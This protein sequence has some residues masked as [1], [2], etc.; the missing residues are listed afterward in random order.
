MTELAKTPKPHVRSFAGLRLGNG[1][2]LLSGRWRAACVY[3]RISLGR[4]PRSSCRLE[5]HEPVVWR[6]K[7]QSIGSP[8]FSFAQRAT[9]LGAFF[10]VT[11]PGLRRDPASWVAW[12]WHG[13]GLLST[14]ISA[15]GA[16]PMPWLLRCLLMNLAGH[17]PVDY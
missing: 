11:R 13:V 17:R 3:K 12:C 2:S 4:C 16:T 7:V 1:S 10:I 9:M 6:L 15:P 5:R 8:L 14:V